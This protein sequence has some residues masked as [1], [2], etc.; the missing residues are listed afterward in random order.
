MTTAVL[1]HPSS[2]ATRSIPSLTL[3]GTFTFISLLG[4]FFRS[5]SASRRSARISSPFSK[6]YGAGPMPANHF[7]LIVYERPESNKAPAVASLGDG[8]SGLQLSECLWPSAPSAC[9]LPA[10]RLEHKP[11]SHL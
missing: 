7:L 5:K 11:P 3:S 10:P 2:S 9:V 4:T 6:D 8:H 1:E